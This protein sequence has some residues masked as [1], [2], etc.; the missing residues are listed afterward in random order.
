MDPENIHTPP[1][2]GI[3]ISCGVE[4][5]VRPK[6]VRCVKLYW[7][8]QRGGG[9]RENPFRGEGI[10]GYFCKYTFML[11]W[12]QHDVNLTI[13]ENNVWVV[14]LLA[15]IFGNQRLKDFREKGE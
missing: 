15:V 8:F 4:G 11:P 12:Q 13:K 9:L 3:S 5:S 7:N 10:N 2:E 6:N 1:T 14:S